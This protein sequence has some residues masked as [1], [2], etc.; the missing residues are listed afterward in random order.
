MSSL[1]RH[2]GYLLIDHR[3]SPGVPA[4]PD[5]ALVGA[6]RLFESATITCSHCQAV[7]ILN[8]DRSRPRHYCAKCD[9]YVCD[10]PECVL[11][12]DPMQARMDRL[13]VQALTLGDPP[14]SR[15]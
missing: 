13:A 6:G 8:P 1:R 5:P 10:K 11:V 2:E 3:V 9:H 14:E 15:R 12:C 7:V 4:G